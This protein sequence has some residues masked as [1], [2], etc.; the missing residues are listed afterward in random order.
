MKKKYAIVMFGIFLC[1]LFIGCESLPYSAATIKTAETHDVF[2][3]VP[4]IVEYEKISKERVMDTCTF[5]VYGENI[6][7]VN[8]KRS[9]IVKCS[10]RYGCDVIVNPSY[11]ILNESNVVTIVVSG[12]PATYKIIRQATPDELWMVNF[13]E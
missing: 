4:M 11:D 8:L 10:K 9:A 5:R 13:K 3:S 6:D 1:V 7:Y 2:V 12:F